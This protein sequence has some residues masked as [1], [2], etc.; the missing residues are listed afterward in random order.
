MRAVVMTAVICLA[1]A[2]AASAQDAKAKGEAVFA[3]LS[4]LPSYRLVYGDP[5]AAAVF[6][7]SVLNTHH[8]T[9]DRP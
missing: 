1:A 2:A 5:S 4:R 7:R 9:E 8:V 6:F 3:A